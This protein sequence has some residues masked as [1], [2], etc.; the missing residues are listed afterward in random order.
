VSA[1]RLSALAE[2]GSAYGR[3]RLA[4]GWTIGL[5]GPDAKVSHR[6]QSSPDRLADPEHG[7]AILAGRGIAKNPVV[8]LRASGLIGVDIDGLAGRDLLNRLVPDGFPATVVVKSGHGWHAWFRPCVGARHSKIEFA[9]DGLELVSDGYLVIPPAVHPSGREYVFA[10]G[11]APWEIELA[12]FPAA[13]YDALLKHSRRSGEHER[14]DDASPLP[15]GARHRHLRRVAGA[16]RR[17]GA[18]EASIA[19][20]LLVENQRRCDPPKDERVVREL[21]RDIATRYPA[22]ARA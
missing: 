7:A 1:D 20:A 16:M 17:A 8:S 12:E 19:A 11:R 21:A 5:D 3:L 9:V 10:D 6:W 22:G 18:G 4:I 13:I 15:P 2:H 14:G